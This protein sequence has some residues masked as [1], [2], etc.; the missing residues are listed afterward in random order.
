M[1][2]SRTALARHPFE[3][4]AAAH[5]LQHLPG[6]RTLRVRHPG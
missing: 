4:L 5:Q 1:S 6:V 2:P 3:T